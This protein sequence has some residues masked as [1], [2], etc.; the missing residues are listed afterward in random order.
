MRDDNWDSDEPKEIQIVNSPS[1]LLDIGSDLEQHS[2][3]VMYESIADDL[4]LQAILKRGQ[5]YKEFD[6][7]QRECGE[8]FGVSQ[9]T[10]AN[11]TILYDEKSNPLITGCNHEISAIKLLTIIRKHKA[12]EAEEVEDFELTREQFQGGTTYRSDEAEALADEVVDMAADEAPKVKVALGNKA[13]GVSR[14]KQVLESDLDDEEKVEA[15]KSKKNFDRIVLGKEDKAPPKNLTDAKDRNKILAEE[16]SELKA[17]NKELEKKLK[18]F[19]FIEELAWHSLRLGRMVTQFAKMKTE[20]KSMYENM[21]PHIANAL[22]LLKLPTTQEV[23]L[24]E[25]KRAFRDEAKAHHPDVGGDTE[26]FHKVKEAYDL[27]KGHL[28]GKK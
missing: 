14:K 15:M 22:Q 10:V 26:V 2:A 5:L 23:T 17:R 25:V 3:A 11:Y 19:N 6:G 18:D 20:S 27:L 16:N 7:T 13:I 4:K 1:D 21:K 24:D 12:E 28:N 8:Y 9:A